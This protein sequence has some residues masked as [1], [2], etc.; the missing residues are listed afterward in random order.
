MIHKSNGPK[1]Q[2]ITLHANLSII[3]THA[4]MCSAVGN[5]AE[6]EPSTQQQQASGPK[7]H[8]ENK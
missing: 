7:K 2:T 4:P 1:L 8:A 3:S 5:V 6:S